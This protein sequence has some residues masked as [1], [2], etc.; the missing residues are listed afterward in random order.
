MP[1]DRLA[2]TPSHS[3]RQRPGSSGNYRTA[4]TTTNSRP[5]SGLATV[6]ANGIG[7]SRGED[8]I[9][10]RFGTGLG[11][12][13][14]STLAV[15]VDHGFDPPSIDTP[16]QPIP[17]IHPS[18][19]ALSPIG[20]IGI[21]LGAATSKPKSYIVDVST[22]ITHPFSWSPGNG[23]SGSGTGG[24]RG[25]ALSSKIA[26]IK[27]KVQSDMHLG[28]SIGHR[29][30]NGS[31]TGMIGSVGGGGWMKGGEAGMANTNSV[32]EDGSSD[33]IVLAGSGVSTSTAG[34]ALPMLS[35]TVS[36][37]YDS[38]RTRVRSRDV[39]R[40]RNIR[41]I[42]VQPIPSSPTLVEKH[43]HD[44]DVG[45]REYAPWTD[46]SSTSNHIRQINNGGH[47]RPHNHPQ[48]QQQQLRRVVGNTPDHNNLRVSPQRK[49]NF[50]TGWGGSMESTESQSPPLVA[51]K[52][53]RLGRTKDSS[54]IVIKDAAEGLVEEADDPVSSSH[55][56]TISE[57]NISA[58]V[59][60]DT[61]QQQ[62]MAAAAAAT[63][64]EDDSEDDDNHGGN[65]SS[66]SP[67]YKRLKALR[68]TGQLSRPIIYDETQRPIGPKTNGL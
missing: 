21:G 13:E 16:P 30:I 23:Y 67:S 8:G 62:H 7:G 19:S 15:I 22:P 50:T 28:N 5:A 65:S 20:G 63:T 33:G 64:T 45:K 68:V 61:Y 24:S 38:D 54:T 48:R 40:E 11:S 3:S 34:R 47:G 18:T 43:G 52:Y 12:G 35:S 1:V 55:T 58:S 4:T 29:G 41:S 49:A 60:G 31:A 59:G 6:R 32:S 2:N 46:A 66:V 26:Q 44:K 57:E 36:K 25:F 37:N 53:N 51:E 17:S 14:R 56:V 39:S 42:P 9:T 27:H 10:R